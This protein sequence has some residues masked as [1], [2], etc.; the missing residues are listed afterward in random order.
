MSGTGDAST[1]SASTEDVLMFPIPDHYGD[2]TPGLDAALAEI[3]RRY[4]AHPMRRALRAAACY[5]HGDPMRW[6]VEMQLS[7]DEFADMQG[8]SRREVDQL[9][10]PARRFVERRTP[11]SER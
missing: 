11:R 7:L 10:V 6:H 9:V 2:P 5:N 1:V 4:P 8:L 3:D